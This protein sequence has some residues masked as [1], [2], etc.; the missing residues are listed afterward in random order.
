MEQARPLLPS[1][2]VYCRDAIDAATGAH[3]LVVITEWNEFRAIS[4]ARLKS[5]MRG[6]TIVDLRN[7]YDPIA[8]RQVG[9]SYHSIGRPG[10]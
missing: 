5:V 4:P 2:V 6:A 7:V 10:G 8:M 3:A 9:F 1:G